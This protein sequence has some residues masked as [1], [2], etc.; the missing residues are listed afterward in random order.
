MLLFP[1]LL[2]Q[3][4]PEWEQQYASVIAE[5]KQQR[6]ALAERRRALADAR[7]KAAAEAKAVAEAAAA[8][9]VAAP[10]PAPAGAVPAAA[11]AGLPGQLAA[12][13]G[14]QGVAAQMQMAFMQQLMSM[15]GTGGA[16]PVMPR[17][18]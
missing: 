18:S 16:L 3:L 6:A 5:H 7:A 9:S 2:P 15:Q 4:K 8:A 11:L 17:P 12:Q 10:V 1:S 14:Q 13:Q